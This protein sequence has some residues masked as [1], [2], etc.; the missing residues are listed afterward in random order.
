[1]QKYTV[2]TMDKKIL[3]IYNPRAG[4][5]RIKNTLSE[6]I[7]EFNENSFE[8][9]TYATRQREDATNI[10]VECL[11]KEEYEYV[12][13]SGGDG[14]L[15]EVINGVMKY[16]KKPKIGYIP[17]GTTN[18]CAYS[19]KLSNNL[20]KAAKGIMVNNIFQW[21]IGS[22]N[23]KYFV[24]NAAFG[25]FTDTAYHTPQSVKNILGKL[26]YFLEGIKSI[27]S[28]KPC[29][30]EIHYGA[31]T[32]SAEFIYG[33]ITNSFSIGGFKGLAGK[34]VCLDDGKFEGIFIKKPGNILELQKIIN[35][36]RKG[37]LN[38][39]F[40]VSVPVTDIYITS[41]EPVP[42]GLDGEFGGNLKEVYIKNHKQ[43]I[44]IAAPLENIN[45]FA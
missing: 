8:V 2:K 30:M 34:N 9:I 35:D 16:A 13:C 20:V 1:M 6:I 28:C 43:K 3:F 36:L 23:E 25:L 5:G 24:Y 31:T 27:T 12:V 10:V 39:E 38:S 7:E 44:S 17:A 18:D 22:F 26:A 15:S 32:I 29:K 37:S 19:L 21:D 4:K 11:G 42:W 33:M 41:D 40:I 14:T 45:N